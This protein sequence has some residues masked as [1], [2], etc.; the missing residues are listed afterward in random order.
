MTVTGRG[1]RLR[2]SVFERDWPFLCNTDKLHIL[3]P[4][5]EYEQKHAEEFLVSH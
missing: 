5:S 4:I 2:V 3:R 1:K